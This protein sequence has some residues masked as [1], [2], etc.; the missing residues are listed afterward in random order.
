MLSREAYDS[1]FSLLSN[2][3][4]SLSVLASR[5]G[6]MF[7]NPVRMTALT[8]LSMLLV[9][10]LLDHGQ[11]IAATWLLCHEF[12]LSDSP[13]SPVFAFLYDLRLTSPNSCSP[14]L[15]DILACILAAALPDGL[16]DLSVAAILSPKFAIQIP[17]TT[18]PTS[19]ATRVSPIIVDRTDNS[20]DQN[21]QGDVVAELLIDKTIFDG[22]DTE[23]VRL[24]PAVAQIFPGELAATFVASFS[25]P[26]FLFD[27]N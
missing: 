2:D 25:R 10:L 23:F 13:F 3:S 9:D 7:D 17:K 12:P 22:F 24:A 1:I 8:G 6:T 16:A 26:I 5:F 11:Q 18:A 15:Y 20:G 21:G 27:D 14:Q 19:D 4:D